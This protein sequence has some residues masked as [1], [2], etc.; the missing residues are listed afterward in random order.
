MELVSN[1]EIIEYQKNLKKKKMEEQNRKVDNYYNKLIS[2]FNSDK[3]NN[4]NKLI[5]RISIY[6]EDINS[7]NTALKQFKILLYSKHYKI[8]QILYDPLLIDCPDI[9]TYLYIY[10][11]KR[12]YEPKYTWYNKILKYIGLYNQI[13]YDYLN[14]EN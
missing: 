5:H 10:I 9:G 13:E 14:Q 6:Y 8:I 2:T 1:E 4:G 12:E 7:F 3:L 11:S